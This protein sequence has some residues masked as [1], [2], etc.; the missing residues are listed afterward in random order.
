MD[1]SGLLQTAP[2]R[3]SKA[4]M[5]WKLIRAAEIS[6]CVQLLEISVWKKTA[7]TPPAESLHRR[8]VEGSLTGHQPGRATNG[9][10]L[11]SSEPQSSPMKNCCSGEA[12]EGNMFVSSITHHQAVASHRPS[13]LECISRYAAR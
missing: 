6:L 4:N 8:D 13:M 9:I 12:S 2:K 3:L 1:G 11:D 7:A 5:I 10:D